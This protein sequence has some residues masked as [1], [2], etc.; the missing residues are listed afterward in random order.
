MDNSAYAGGT[1]CILMHFDRDVLCKKSIDFFQKVV[2]VAQ[3]DS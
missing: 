2:S 3:I 1:M